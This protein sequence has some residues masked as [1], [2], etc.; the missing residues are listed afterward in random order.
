MVAPLC[1]AT[2]SH[3]PL[4]NIREGGKAVM[5]PQS[6]YRLNCSR[7]NG[8]AVHFSVKEKDEASQVCRSQLGPVEKCFDFIAFILR[9]SWE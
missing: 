4:E 9:L 1:W 2:N 5:S 8:A 6:G 3:R 7:R